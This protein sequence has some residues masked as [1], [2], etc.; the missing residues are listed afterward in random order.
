MHLKHFFNKF[1]NTID[2][3]ASQDNF[4]YETNK[5]LSACK[6][7]PCHYRGDRLSNHSGKANYVLC[8]LRLIDI[9]LYFCRWRVLDKKT[10]AAVRRVLLNSCYNIYSQSIFSFVWNTH[11]FVKIKL[12]IFQQIFRVYPFYKMAANL[13]PQY[14]QIGKA[15]V[16]QYYNI[17]DN[18]ATRWVNE[19]NPILMWKL[20]SIND[21]L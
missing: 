12:I 13:N 16:E 5:L 3:L 14:E 17:F 1:Y 6:A 8:S 18:V 19:L 21:Y 7:D 10:A 4:I 20:N 15:F 9:V 2:I 11:C